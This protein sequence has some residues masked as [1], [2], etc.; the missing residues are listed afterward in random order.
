MAGLLCSL[1]VC[2][3]AA[4]APEQATVPESERMDVNR[5]GMT[6]LEKLPGVTEV[7]AG[8]IVRFRPYRSKLDL[9]N[10]GVI[11][12]RVYHRIEGLIIAHRE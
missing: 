6:E 9:V 8:R 1:A 2:P 7:W 11:P 5:A 12:P 10:K 3:Q 4:R